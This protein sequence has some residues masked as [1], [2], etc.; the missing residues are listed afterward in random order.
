MTEIATE[1]T[2]V[3]VISPSDITRAA[4]IP[5]SKPEP[6]EGRG[7]LRE[8]SKELRDRRPKREPLREIKYQDGAKDAEDITLRKAGSDLNFTRRMEK[9][10][11]LLAEG[12]SVEQ[13][14][15][16]D[17]AKVLPKPVIDKKNRPS[18]T[19]GGG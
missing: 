3:P 18:I 2:S 12:A 19:A 1:T 10:S 14:I 9:G 8:A 6:I 11:R 4:G 15:R 13:A 16:E 7:A 5:E 17:K